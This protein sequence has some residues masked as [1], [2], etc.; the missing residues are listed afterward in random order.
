GPRLFHVFLFLKLRH[1]VAE[2]GNNPSHGCGLGRPL[3]TFNQA[4]AWQGVADL[5]GLPGGAAPGTCA[6]GRSS[7][8]VYSSSTRSRPSAVVLYRRRGRRLPETSCQSEHVW[9]GGEKCP[10][11]LTS[12]ERH[13]ILLTV[14]STAFKTLIPRVCLSMRA[15]QATQ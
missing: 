9:H 11:S 12:T 4:Q 10:C 8:S 6:R 2:S 5:S 15:G 14:I 1:G 7:K 13:R 3:A